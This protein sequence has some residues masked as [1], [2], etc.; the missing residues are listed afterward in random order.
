MNTV[1]STKSVEFMPLGLTVGASL[2][3]F[4][5]LAYGWCVGDWFILVP[6]GGGAI[7]C[8]AQ[9]MLYCTYAGTEES[10]AAF[11]RI[12]VERRSAMDKERAGD[13]LLKSREAAMAV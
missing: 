7:L 10:R 11:E 6:N 13:P 12:R 9:I 1:I 3:S 5:W 4:T 2:C 8:S